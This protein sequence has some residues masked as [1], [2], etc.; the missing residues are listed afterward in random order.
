MERC[1]IVIPALEP[2]R[3]F[4]G[5]IDELL[6]LHIGPIVVVDDGSGMQYRNLFRSVNA[7]VDG[8]E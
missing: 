8:T 6:Q 5:F 2:R 1:V 3:D 7:K 4:A